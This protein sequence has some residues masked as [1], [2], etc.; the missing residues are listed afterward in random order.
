MEHHRPCRMLCSMLTA[1]ALSIALVGCPTCPPCN[2]EGESAQFNIVGR[3]GTSGTNSLFPWISGGGS[4]QVEV[5]F[6]STGR[7][8]LAFR[9]LGSLV[10][11]ESGD[12]T[13][14]LESDPP[15][16]DLNPTQ[17][18]YPSSSP[19][20]SQ[21]NDLLPNLAVV[22]IRGP[23]AVNIGFSGTSST[24]GNDRPLGFAVSNVRMNLSRV[25]T[26]KSF[27][28]YEYL[29]CIRSVVSWS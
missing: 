9:K 2:G 17:A 4:I 11:S 25:T 14:N 10:A 21:Q 6:F 16:L 29:N 15:T 22:E 28:P 19:F 26:S 20:S 8:T 5:E 23:D 13:L 1:V 27:S 12:Y 24:W 3:W 7:Y 18:S